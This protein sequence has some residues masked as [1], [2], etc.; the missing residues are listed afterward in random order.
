MLALSALAEK[1]DQSP[2]ER[3][4]DTRDLFD[5]NKFQHKQI[6]HQQAL[7]AALDLRTDVPLRLGLAK[8]GTGAREDLLL[9]GYHLL[10]A[11]DR[12][13]LDVCSGEDLFETIEEVYPRPGA[14][15]LTFRIG[16]PSHFEL[17]VDPWPFDAPRFDIDVP[18]RRVP[19]QKYADDDEF[20]RAYSAASVEPVTVNVRPF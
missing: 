13:S 17:A 7:R 14:Q 2:H 4:R 11:M 19:A 20:R 15:P 16:H 1:R 9:F 12:I 6:E 5:L 10:K 8:P 3:H 18:G